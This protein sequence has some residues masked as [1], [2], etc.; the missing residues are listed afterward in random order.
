MYAEIRQKK[1]A[2]RQAAVQP[3][4]AAPAPTATPPGEWVIRP[5]V[6]PRLIGSIPLLVLWI[7]TA[8]GFLEWYSEEASVR[9][10]VFILIGWTLLSALRTLLWV[11]GAKYLISRDSIVAN[12]GIIARRVVKVH[13]T[14]IRSISMS[15]GVFG[16]LF[17]FGAVHVFTAATSGAEIVMRAVPRP[18]EIVAHLEKLRP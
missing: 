11:K 9:V 6:V 12:Y 2:A 18:E 1:A 4:P 5:S 15:Q 7:I 16:R 14:D 3:K 13:T 8:L 17:G 10:W